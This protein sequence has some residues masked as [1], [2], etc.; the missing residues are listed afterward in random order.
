MD[1]LSKTYL[2]KALTQL[3]KYLPNNTDTLLSWYD[4]HPDYYAVTTIGKYVYC[5]FAL[6]VI[7]SNGKE[8][9]YV[10]RLIIIY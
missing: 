6:P 5:L 8:I 4:N 2:T 9:K 10:V 1:K 7:S 3:E